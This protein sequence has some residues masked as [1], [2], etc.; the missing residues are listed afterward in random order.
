MVVELIP[1]KFISSP[2]LSLALT[3]CLKVLDR[4]SRIMDFY[5]KF[6]KKPLKKIRPVV[7][8]IKSEMCSLRLLGEKHLVG[9]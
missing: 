1:P 4:R 3:M 5:E 8:V 6:S 7:D 2:N 9:A